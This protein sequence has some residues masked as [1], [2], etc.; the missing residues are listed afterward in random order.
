[1]QHHPRRFAAQFFCTLF[2]AASISFGQ[3]TDQVIGVW[4]GAIQI[5]GTPLGVT[6]EFTKT[7]DGTIQ[8]DIDIPMQ[9]ARDLQLSNISATGKDVT[10]SISGIPGSPTFSGR[11]SVDGSTMTG[12]FKQA[13]QTFPFRLQKQAAVEAAKALEAQKTKLGMIRAFIDSTKG[14]WNT[15]GVAM[16][17]VK[18]DEVIFSEG[19]GN[20]DVEKNLPVTDKTLFA[21][22]SSSKAFTAASVGL[23]VADG[24]LEWEIGRAHV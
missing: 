8:G 19:F 24:K 6:A 11:I 18:G 15:P 22:G 10:F 20:R 3:A 12:D 16:A 23:M 2:V 7:G 1:M 9:N 14:A 17:I 5:P 21:I 4:E 13:G